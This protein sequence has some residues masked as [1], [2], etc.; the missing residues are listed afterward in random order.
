MLLQFQAN[1]GISCKESQADDS[2]TDVPA[3]NLDLGGVLCNGQEG[4]LGQYSHTLCRSKN[5][6]QN[7]KVCWAVELSG[8][9]QPERK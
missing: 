3:K 7:R 4:K 8:W 6:E 1:F 9:V 2:K 5:E